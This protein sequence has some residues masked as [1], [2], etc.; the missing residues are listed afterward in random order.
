MKRCNPYLSATAVPLTV[1]LLLALPQAAAAH[2]YLEASAPSA[3]ARLAQSPSVILMRFDEPLTKLSSAAVYNAATDARIPATVDFPHRLELA[4]TPTSPLLRGSYRVEWHSVSAV[5]GHAVEGSFAFGVRAAAIG[6]SS[7]AGPLANLGWLRAL[8]RAALYAALFTFVGAVLLNTLL[9]R[10]DESWLLPAPVADLLSEGQ[11]TII[12]RR[13]EAVLTASGLAA[14]VLAV[15]SALVD[16]QIAAG[17]LGPEAIR[18]YLF[19]GTAGFAQ[20]GLVVLLVVAVTAA[21]IRAR[22]AAVVA[23]L[24]LGEL[25]LSGHANAAHPRA[26]AILLDWAH[27]LA[28][29]VWLGGITILAVVWLPEIRGA[30]AELRR[31]VMATVLPRF[32]RVA[33]PAFAAV[34]ITGAASAYLEIRHPALLWGSSYGRVLLVKSGIVAAL[35]LTSYRHAIRL[36]PRLLRDQAPDAALQRRHWRLLG[37]EPIIGVA[38]AVSVALLVSFGPPAERAAASSGTLN[39]ASAVCNPCVLP[40]P[41]KNELSVATRVG[42]NVVAA[43]IRH[44]SG[45][46]SGQVR[47]INYQDQPS[48]TPFEIAN[49]ASVGVTCGPGCRTFRIAGTARTVRV[50]LNPDRQAMS[51][52]LPT[53]WQRRGSGFA[54]ALLRRADTKMN[55]LRSV[56]DVQTVQSIAGLRAVTHYRLLAPNRSSSVT[57]RIRGHG[58]AVLENA[59]VSIGPRTW[60]LEPGFGWHLQPAEGTLPFATNTWFLWGTFAQSTRLIGMR[61]VNGRRLARIQLMDPGTPAWWTLLIDPS[62]DLVIR[63]TLTMPGYTETEAMSAFNRPARISAPRRR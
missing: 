2:A 14:V 1:A 58:P 54:A 45:G 34:V 53:R 37:A 51:A 22:V 46:L 61:T 4:L 12:T 15:A 18:G 19:T 17:D 50:I 3:G 21:V 52:A 16:T 29:A 30:G 11:R 49:A 42:S 62:D 60:T 13:V 20:I 43:W 25:A 33:L 47:V 27:V 56:V 32:G 23:A 55:A 31:T 10:R 9:G 63:G 26:V 7:T 24:A 36:R 6:G 40:L 8:V 28:G 5:D 39:A 41:A 38:L 35:A 48:T 59:Q 44:G 57:Y